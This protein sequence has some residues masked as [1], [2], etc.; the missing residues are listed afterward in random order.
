MA[1]GRRAARGLERPPAA[2]PPRGAPGRPRRLRGSR[3]ARGRR[4]R[5]GVRRRGP[6][7]R[8][9]RDGR[10]APGARAR[11]AGRRGVHDAPGRGRRV[12]APT[13]VL[14][15]LRYAESYKHT[16]ALGYLKAYADAALRGKVRTVILERGARTPPE[17]VAA[18]VLAE[19]PAF[20]G[21]SCYLWNV[22]AVLA[23]CRE[24][25]RLRPGLLTALGGP[26]ATPRAEALL[27][28]HP[29]VDLVARGEGEETYAELM[30]LLAAGARA[31]GFGTGVAGTLARDGARLVAGPERPHIAD[32]AR[33][34]S[35][36][37]DG[38]FRVRTGD[39]LVLE[40][41]RGCPL[42]CRFC[43]WQNK[44]PRRWFPKERALAEVAAAARQA[45]GLFYFVSDSDV[46]ADKARAEE[47]LDA[48]AR[49]TRDQAIHWHFQTTLA[50]ID[51][52]LARRLDSFKF[53][54][55]AGIETV[56]RAPLR[57]M[58]RGFDRARTERAAEL[59]RTLAPRLSVHIQLIHG[60]PDDDLAGY[61]G[62]LE[63]ALARKPDV[64]FLPR[65]LALPGADF[66]REA[67]RY[68][69]R[70]SAAPPYEVTATESFS[71]ADM[72][73]A[74]R[75]AFGVLNVH[76]SGPLRRA[77]E[78]LEGAAE[79]RVELHEALWERL[80][81]ALP[82]AARAHAL[83]EAGSALS[84]VME[85]EPFNWWALPPAERVRAVGETAALCRAEGGGAAVEGLLRAAE[86]DALW[87]AFV[88]S[89]A[90]R[91]L[92]GRLLGELPADS[93]R[94]QW[95]GWEGF[96][97]EWGVCPN[98]AVTHVLSS[99][100]YDHFAACPH[101]H[102]RH[103]HLEDFGEWEKVERLFAGGH[104][105]VLAV[106]LSNVYGILPEAKRVPFL[107][108]VR[109]CTHTLGRLV[110]WFDGA[111]R[112]PHEWRG[113]HPAPGQ[114][115]P[116][117]E[118]VRREL[119]E[120]GWACEGGARTV[121]LS[122]PLAGKVSWTFLTAV[123]AGAARDPKAVERVRSFAQ[124]E[125]CVYPT[126]RC[127][128]DCVFCSSP[129]EGREQTQAE[130]EALVGR[131]GPTLSIE[132]GEPTLLLRRGL[133]ELAAAAKAAGTREV[134]LCTNGAALERPEAVRAL[135]KA[136]V[137]EFNVN[138]PAHEAAL[139][140][141]LTRTRDRFPRRVA[142]VRNLLA[143]AGPGRTRLTHVVCSRNA[144]RLPEFAAWAAGAFPGLRRVAFNLVKVLGYVRADLGLVPRLSEAGPPLREALAVCR[145][146]GL[147]AFVDGFPLCHL[148]GFEDRSVD[149]QK[150]PGGDY[151]HS[152]EK[153]HRA[154]CA[155]CARRAVCAGPREDYVELHGDG[156]LRSL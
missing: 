25:K 8:R 16:L 87:A 30:L 14:V 83:Y 121:S 31:P 49:L 149:L 78:M 131:G 28:E 148:T 141:A 19:E 66:G 134:V 147:E 33:I 73:A 153:T 111:G 122:G 139:F 69:I 113:P 24:L 90:F 123:P 89:P 40:T 156:E 150:F 74:D 64:L 97:R 81:A 63:W 52:G 17:R 151:A 125:P 10:V 114:A 72:R 116:T 34:P 76:R 50:R 119:A 67:A 88:E 120:A 91:P 108:L 75:L 124:D 136:G 143:T 145:A 117:P 27:R 98:A 106:V 100:H 21:F 51:E 94:V 48:F 101:P 39:S 29:E 35:P 110:L 58:A 77:L 38:T 95:V 53:S 37:L 86:A 41:S 65:A 2:R 36:Y 154:A 4:R 43:D 42:T 32:L 12:S 18:D 22:D 80:K 71:E 13:A 15:G 102:G 9:A 132:G 128:Q 11:A 6:G 107:R 92:V 155:S 135:M 96:S 59:L 126:L 82:S 5:G 112:S 140:D 144:S 99:L 3:D 44:Q 118:G 85:Q 109:E 47:L 60:L 55:G 84:Q 133:P 56:Q 103:V 79:R 46:F 23:T 45:A 93:D 26:E 137:T 115:P 7:G 70:H 152:F 104:R 146:R 127:N 57:R 130:L 142:A 54:L 105:S 1:A 62:S 20:V 129:G 138:L 68:G 61:R